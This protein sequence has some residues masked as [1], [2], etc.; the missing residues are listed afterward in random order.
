MC[1][2]SPPALVQGKKNKNNLTAFTCAEKYKGEAG[3]RQKKYLFIQVCYAS[4][5]GQDTASG[6]SNLFVLKY[7]QKIHC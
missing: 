5:S 2:V 1:R 6:S 3:Q 4:A 7:P